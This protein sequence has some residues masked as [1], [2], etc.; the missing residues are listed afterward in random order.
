ML[1]ISAFLL[2][3]IAIERRKAVVKPLSILDPPPLTKTLGAICAIVLPGFVIQTPTIYGSHYAA[4]NATEIPVFTST[5]KLVWN[6]CPITHLCL[7]ES[8]PLLYFLSTSTKSISTF[9][10]KQQDLGCC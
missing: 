10:Q 9:Q 3:A 5:I 8:Y 6:C 4:K 1:D 7:T 2:A